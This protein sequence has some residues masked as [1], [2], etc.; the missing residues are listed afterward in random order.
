MILNLLYK[1][2]QDNNIMSKIKT[3]RHDLFEKAKENHSVIL[4]CATVQP[5][6]CLSGFLS[7]NSSRLYF[8]LRS[9]FCFQPSC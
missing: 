6:Y 8:C 5:D 9:V 1:I 4:R 2:L 3:K 7:V